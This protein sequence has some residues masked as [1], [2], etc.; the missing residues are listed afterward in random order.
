MERNAAS[1]PN[2]YDGHLTTTHTSPNTKINTVQQWTHSPSLSVVAELASHYCIK[3]WC[4]VSVV[5]RRYRLVSTSGL[6]RKRDYVDVIA[7]DDSQDI[8]IRATRTI[9]SLKR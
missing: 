4:T 2:S 7:L 9:G 6:I 5:P 1:S 3:R 8:S